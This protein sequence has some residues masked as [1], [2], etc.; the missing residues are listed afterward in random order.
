MPHLVRWQE[1]LSSF[2]LVIVAPH[3]QNATEEEI[4]AR[5]RALGVNFSVV[6][7]G[8]V[9]KAELK[10]IP[11]CLLFDHTGECLYQGHPGKVEPWLRSAVGAAL[12]A[13]TGKSDFGR[14]LKPL[15]DALKKG[16]PPAAVLQKLLPLQKSSD[17]QAAKEARLLFEKLTEGGQRQLDEVKELREK[18]PV[19][20]YHQVQRL[21]VAFKGTAVAAKA[22]ELLGEL[23]KDKAVVAELRAQPSLEAIR[24]LDAALS[25]AADKTDP[26][27]VE[28]QRAF[29]APLKQMQA[30][31]Q[32][33]KRSWPDARAT[34]EAVE[35]A[36]KYGVAVK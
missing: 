3:V 9:E 18:D 30:A 7:S 10:A 13:A 34:A 27:S 14:V 29:A 2:G 20:A 1:E 6:S 8:R 4:R 5:A 25:K 36:G 12:V 33:M 11:H 15:A 19:A 22:G 21:T 28:F 31:L 24:K 16:Q 26:K 32:R 17:A 23:K 35:I